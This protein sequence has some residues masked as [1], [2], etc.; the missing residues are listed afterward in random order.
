MALKIKIVHEKKLVDGYLSIDSV[1]T[2]RG[3]QT[4]G[5]SG[6]ISK[7]MAS[8]GTETKE[9]KDPNKFHTVVTYT[10]EKNI[11]GKKCYAAG[12]LHFPYD[13]NSKTNILETAYEELKK[14]ERFKTSEDA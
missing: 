8:N 6:G 9:L 11:D 3:P 7:M 4:S 2:G 5:R 13:L 10:V 1:K 14:I 12:V